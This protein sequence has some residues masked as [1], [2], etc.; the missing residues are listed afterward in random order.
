M[1]TPDF[2]AAEE[3]SLELRSLNASGLLQEQRERLI[4]LAKA[5]QAVKTL[6]TWD[7]AMTVW[8]SE[9]LEKAMTPWRE[10]GHGRITGTQFS[11]RDDKRA[12]DKV[13]D[14]V[15]RYLAMKLLDNSR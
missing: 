8:V 10:L 15:D 5:E 12:I 3:A 7:A 6:K 9:P 1:S 4:Y 11:E 13:L 2:K 14:Q